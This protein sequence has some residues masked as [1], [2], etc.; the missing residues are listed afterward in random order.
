MRISLNGKTAFVSGSTGGIG[1]EIALAYARH[2]ADVI[3]NGRGVDAGEQLVERLEQEGIRATFA[4]SDITDPEALS[5]AVDD[6]AERMGGIDIVVANGAAGSGPSTNF[7]RDMP[8]SEFESMTA[9]HYLSRLYVIDAALEHLIES[10]DGRVVSISSDAGRIPTPGEVL[11]GG[12]AAAVQM[13]TRALAQEFAR[14]EIPVNA[15]APT[16]VEDTELLDQITGDG[17]ASSVFE[18]AL[19]KQTFLVTA[20]DVAEIVLFLTGSPAARPVTGQTI[21]VTGGVAF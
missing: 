2:G 11:P 12:A 15:V 5:V 3:V 6:A 10:D 8:A 9:H 13:A 16:V 21:S 17:P 4:Q 1:R 20:E 18:A 14:W 19:E 7:F